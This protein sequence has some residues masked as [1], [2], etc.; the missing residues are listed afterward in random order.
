MKKPKYAQVEKHFQEIKILRG[1]NLSWKEITEY[2]STRHHLRIE[3]SYIRKTWGELAEKEPP[4]NKK[5]EAIERIRIHMEMQPLTIAEREKLEKCQHLADKRERLLV[6]AQKRNKELEEA[7]K[8]IVVELEE[9]RRQ[10]GKLLYARLHRIATD[11]IVRG[12]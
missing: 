5:Q 10:T 3:E 9:G 8:S 4:P 2:M 1:Q 11:N 12:K 7:L 6:A